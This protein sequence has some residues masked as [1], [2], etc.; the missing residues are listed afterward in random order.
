MPPF[1]SEIADE[2]RTAD[3][4]DLLLVAGLFFLVISWVRSAQSGSAARR[5]MALVFL[6]G[7]VYLAADFFELFLAQTVLGVFFFVVLISLVVVFQ[8]DIRRLLDRLGSVGL[9]RE[10]RGVPLT[11]P[12]HLLTEAASHMAEER[13]GGLIAIRG[14]DPWEA[15]L[16]GGIPLNGQLSRALLD[17]IF[18]AESPGHDGALLVEGDR[19]TRFA[20]HLP[21]ARRPPPISWSGG[22]RHTAALGLSEECDALVIV[23]SEERGTISIAEDGQLIELESAVELNERL[24]EFWRQHYSAKTGEGRRRRRRR[25]L[26]TGA[27]SLGLAAMVWFLFVYSADTVF[28]SYRVPIEIRNLPA[29]WRLDTD[30]V[31]SALVTLSGSEPA[32]DRLDPAELAASFDLSDPE[33][34]VNELTITADNLTVP[35]DFDLIAAD[36]P[37]VEILASRQLRVLL[38]V[39]IRR[40]GLLPPIDS[41]VANPAIVEVMVPSTMGAAPTSIPTEEIDVM[42]IMEEGTLSVPLVLPD[43]VRMAPDRSTEVEV[44]VLRRGEP[45]AEPQGEQLPAVIP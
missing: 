38:P 13:T 16:Q 9:R 15:Y 34:G 6:Y 27:L 42:R 29:D 10:E 14:T 2:F 11:S 5:L 19:V 26:E 35:A 30:E 12:V 7:L 25:R 36:P 21:L 17:S 45:L 28:R 3:L 23:I 32:F 37:S 18:N 43:E 4:I 41:L 39:R 33:D 8:G 44:K 1:V 31:P 40:T 24:G 20:V 22:T